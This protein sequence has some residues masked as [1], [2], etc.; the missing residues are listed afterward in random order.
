MTGLFLID[1]VLQGWLRYKATEATTFKD[2]KLLEGTRRFPHHS[3]EFGNKLE[4][5]TGATY[6]KRLYLNLSTLAPYISGPNSVKVATPLAELDKIKIDPAYLVS[7]T[8]S[9]A[10]DLAA[11]AK[12]F[13]DAA[14]ENNCK[15]PKIADGVNLYIAAASRLEQIAAEAAGDW[16]ALIEAGAQPLPAGCG[17]CIGLGTGLLQP[18][19][20]GVS[21]SNRNQGPPGQYQKPEG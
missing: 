21:A 5:D 9:L 17:L 19:E 20:I 8:N 12:V 14:K 7:C 18:G 15:I 10:S 16:Q 13:R 11:T 6:A 1:S 3:L 2:H 4:A